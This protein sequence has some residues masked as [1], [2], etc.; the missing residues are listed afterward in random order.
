MSG[1]VGGLG[2]LMVGVGV[3]VMRSRRRDGLAY[4]GRWDGRVC[5][6]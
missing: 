3:W 1:Q 4:V 5:S 2:W 6:G